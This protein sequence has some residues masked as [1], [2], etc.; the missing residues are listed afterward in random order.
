MAAGREQCGGYRTSSTTANQGEQKPDG[1]GDEGYK[2]DPRSNHRE[3]MDSMKRS[4]FRGFINAG[5]L[6]FVTR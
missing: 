2:S 3:G 5:D 6:N 1:T 4:N